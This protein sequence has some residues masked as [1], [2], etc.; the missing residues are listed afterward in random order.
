MRSN[1]F[2]LALVVAGL[3]WAMVA[4]R[5]ASAFVSPSPPPGFERGSDGRWRY[6]PPS[7]VNRP[8]SGLLPGGTL[9][10]PKPGGGT[11]PVPV[12]FKPKPGAIGSA[13]GGLMRRHPGA[14]AA[15]GLGGWLLDNCLK[16]IGGSWRISCGDDPEISWGPWEEPYG[17]TRHHSADAA[18]KAGH[19]YQQGGRLSPSDTPYVAHFGDFDPNKLGSVC[20][21]PAGTTNCGFAVTRPQ[22]IGDPE[23]VPDDRLDEMLETAPI[24]ALPPIPYEADPI[25]NPSPGPDP[26]PMPFRVPIGDPVPRFDPDTGEERWVQPGM[27]MQQLGTPLDPLRLDARP[28]EEPVSSP[29]GSKPP[30]DK[31]PTRPGTET[32]VHTPGGGGGGGPAPDRPD[33]CK[34]NPDILACQKYGDVKEP[35]KLEEQLIKMEFRPYGN[36]SAGSCPAPRRASFFGRPL[37]ISYQPI[38]DFATMIR[39][40]IIAFAYFAAA[41]IFVGAARR[42]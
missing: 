1:P 24:P 12:G 10:L 41:L 13:I 4:P 40:L 23:I 21:G 29:Q 11:H 38:C 37:D 19:T 28:Y 32:G 2:L 17:K 39:P 5:A 3:T 15:L 42:S 6:K 18:C 20:C 27:E 31:P 34:A 7:P 9:N 8:G 36:A 26:Q 30:G 33:V 25:V 22:I 14:A 16:H 35:P